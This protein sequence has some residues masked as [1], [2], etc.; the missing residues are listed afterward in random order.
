LLPYQSDAEQQTMSLKALTASDDLTL[1]PNEIFRP[2]QAEKYFGLRH[3]QLAVKVKSGEIPAP[4][5]LSASGSAVG[6]LGSQIIEYHRKVRLAL[7]KKP[8]G[9]HN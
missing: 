5:K 7:T 2:K 6:W 8:T 9:D 4:I 1:D 3:A